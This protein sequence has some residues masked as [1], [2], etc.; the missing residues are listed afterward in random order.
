M[1][2]LLIL[3]AI[4]FETFIFGLLLTIVLL[5]VFELVSLKE[6]LNIRINRPRSSFLSSMYSYLLPI[7]FFV[8]GVLTT[9][10][11]VNIILAYILGL[12]TIL[13]LGVPFVIKLKSKVLSK[14]MDLEVVN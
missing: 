8:V 5:V 14:F 3:G 1:L 7:I 11:G 6:E 2:T 13:L 12:V 10:A 9:N 4:S